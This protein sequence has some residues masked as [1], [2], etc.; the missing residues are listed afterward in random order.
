LSSTVKK[1]KDFFTIGHERSI[2]VKKNILLS[3]FLKGISVVVSFLMVPITLN[4][5][6]VERYG[7]WLTLSSIIGWFYILDIG[8]GNGL[9]NKFTETLAKGNRE[10]ARI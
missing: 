1:I 8:L 10:L 6:N 9:R 5:L 2:K 4:Y 7:I 3:F